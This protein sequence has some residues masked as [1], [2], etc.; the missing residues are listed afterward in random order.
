MR[1]PEVHPVQPE[2]H[3]KYGD[4]WAVCAC[5]YIE[6]DVPR[7]SDEAHAELCDML[8]MH[9]TPYQVREMRTD[10]EL[11]DALRESH[12]TAEDLIESPFVSL[13]KAGSLP[14]KELRA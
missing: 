14:A 9:P 13:A 1:S 4:A 3:A 5:G 8:L 6:Y 12:V 7:D 10:I 11:M 2:P